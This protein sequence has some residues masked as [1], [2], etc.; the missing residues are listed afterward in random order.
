MDLSSNNSG[1]HAAIFR[2]S[3]LYGNRYKGFNRQGLIGSM[4]Q[5]ILNCEEIEFFV[6]LSTRRDFIH[7]EDAALLVSKIL[8]N[9]DTK[10]S[11]FIKIVAA[12]RTYSIEDIL[13]VFRIFIKHPI[14]FRCSTND[15][16]KIYSKNIEF[17]S[18]V[19][20]DLEGLEIRD[21]HKGV[22]DLLSQLS[23]PPEDFK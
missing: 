20:V 23:S 11:T 13:D 3:T 1:I 6:P 16:S 7:V 15:F 10:P 21:L 4:A 5:K 18:N 17:R 9:M 12:E 22:N 19:F 8:K 14:K 2:L